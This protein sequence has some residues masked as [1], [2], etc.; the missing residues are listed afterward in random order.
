MRLKMR[1]DGRGVNLTTGKLRWILSLPPVFQKCSKPTYLQAAC[2]LGEGLL[3]E[4]LVRVHFGSWSR[5]GAGG[6]GPSGVLQQVWRSRI[7]RGPELPVVPRTFGFAFQSHQ[8]DS[9]RG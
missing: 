6:S 8:S 3:S 1:G 4:G 7:G 2:N 5:T 9:R